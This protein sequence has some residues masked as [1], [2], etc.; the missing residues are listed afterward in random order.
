MR[1][2]PEMRA[3]AAHAGASANVWRTAKMHSAASAE[4]SSAA[5]ATHGVRRSTATAVSSAATSTTASSRAGVSSTRQN[6][7]QS[8]DAENLEI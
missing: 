5:A 2:A 4:V 7:C 1:P 6:G 8:N 3:T